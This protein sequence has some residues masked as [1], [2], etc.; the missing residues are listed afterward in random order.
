MEILFG[1]AA[2][3]LA[4]YYYFTMHFDFWIVRSVPGPKPVPFFGNILRPMFGKL[5]LSEFLMELR[6]QY[7]DEPLVGLIVRRTPNLV[8]QDSDLIKDVLIKD[9]PKFSDRG[10][11]RNEVVSS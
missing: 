4:L 11:L 3:F 1:V 10:F 2:V 5:S 9:F 6:E 7:K 8:I